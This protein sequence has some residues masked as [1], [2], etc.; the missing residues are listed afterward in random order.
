VIRSGLYKDRRDWCWSPVSRQTS[1][2]HPLGGDCQY[3]PQ[4]PWLPSQP[5]SIIGP[6][7]NCTAWLHSTSAN[8]LPVVTFRTRRSRGD[9]YWSRSSVCLSVCPSQHSHTT[10]RTPMQVVGNRRGCPL[11]V[12]YSANLQSVHGF[13]CYDN[14]APNVK[15]QQVLVFTPFLV[16]YTIVKQLRAEPTTSQLW[17]N[18]PNHYITLV[19]LLTMCKTMWL[20]DWVGF[21]DPLNT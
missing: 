5:H 6:V 1:H 13:R 10:A 7:L 4:G 2:S 17:I 16:N 21:N 14:I 3:S 9:L 15:C 8:K 19:D 11:V 12:H 20:I 18:C